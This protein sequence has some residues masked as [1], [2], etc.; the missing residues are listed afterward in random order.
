MTKRLFGGN[1]NAKESQN[2]KERILEG[3]YDRSTVRSPKHN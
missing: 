1:K 2:E 3:D